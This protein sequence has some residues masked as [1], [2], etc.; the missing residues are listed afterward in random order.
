M[1][2]QQTNVKKSGSY[3]DRAIAGVVLVCIFAFFGILRLAENGS[4]RPGYL[5]GVCG[6]KQRYGLPCPGCGWTHSAQAFAAG[7]V[8]RS[9]VL[10][11]AAAVF[12]GLLVIIAIL[13]LHTLIFGIYSRLLRALT[14]SRF[15]KYSLIG[16]GIVILLGWIVT[17]ARALAAR[18]GL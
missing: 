5:L 4:I 8:V 16:L 10:Q 17:L 3:A 1:E 14:S 9:F 15:W 12:C 11:P 7:D 13:A 2:C 18:G 6:F